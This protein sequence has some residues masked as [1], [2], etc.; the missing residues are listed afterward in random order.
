MNNKLLYGLCVCTLEFALLC[1]SRHSNIN[2][3]CN[4]TIQYMYIC[5]SYCMVCAY[6]REDNPRALASGLSPVHTH[7]PYN[8]CLI[9]PACM[10]TKIY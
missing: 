7:K 10:C 9:A 8:N 3:R 6:V 4:N 5:V 1:I 2:E